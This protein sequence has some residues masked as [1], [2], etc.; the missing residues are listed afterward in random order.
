MSRRVHC[1]GL[2]DYDFWPY[3]D[4]STDR[5]HVDD[6]NSWGWLLNHEE[7]EDESDVQFSSAKI[8]NSLGEL[9]PNYELKLEHKLNH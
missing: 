9:E 6:D 7:D 4:V 5:C 3:D 8:A 2:A 1:V